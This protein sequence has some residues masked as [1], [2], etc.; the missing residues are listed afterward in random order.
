MNLV[1]LLEKLLEIELSIGKESDLVIRRK[2]QDAQEYV[3]QMQ[4]ERAARL[5]SGHRYSAA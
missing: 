1:A 2:M 3:L 5:L 4:K